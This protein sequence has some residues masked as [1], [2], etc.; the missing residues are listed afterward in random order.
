MSAHA[1]HARPLPRVGTVFTGFA[2]EVDAARWPFHAAAAVSQ[3]AS[4]ANRFFELVQNRIEANEVLEAS[5]AHDFLRSPHT[6]CHA[7]NSL[8]LIW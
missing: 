2:E 6:F 1:H 4:A 7:S 5:V 8:G 3:S